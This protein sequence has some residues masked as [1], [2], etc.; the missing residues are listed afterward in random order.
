MSPR[1]LTGLLVAA[2]LAPLAMS[3]KPPAAPAAKPTAPVATPAAVSRCAA[4]P[5][6]DANAAAVS[7]PSAADAWGGPRT[8]REAT[9]SERIASYRIQATLD[10]DKHTLD[11]RQQL[12]WKNR[13]GQPV[14]AVYLHLYLNAFESS[15]STFMSEQR[16]RGFA[17]RSDVETKDGDWGYI[18]LKRVAQGGQPVEW[19]FVQPDG[20]PATDRTVVRLDLPTPVAPGGSTTLDIDFFNQLPRVVAR[21]G[22]FGSFHL[23][24][25]WFPKIGVL[26]LPGERGATAPRWNV[27]EFHL[28]SEFYADFGD[29][30]VSLT[31]PSEYVVGATGELAGTPVVANGKTTYRYVQGDVHDF[32]W[33]A[34][35]R[36]AQ[37]LEATWTHPGGAPVKVRVLFPPEY[38]DNAPVVMKA[39]LDSLTYF[40][41]T[42]GRYP[43]R[44]VTAVIPP[45]NAGEAGGMEYPTFFTADNVR[46]YRP[47][48]IEQYLLDFVTIHE[49]GHGYFYGILASNEFEEPMLDEGVNQY[50]N[51]RMLV[52]RRQRIVPLPGRFARLSPK[53]SIDALMADRLGA[54]L[55][56]PADP[57]G[58]NSWDRR[59]SGSYATVYS[60]T[61][62]MLAGIEKQVGREAMARAMKLYYE[63]W[64]FRHPSIADF[65]EALAEGTG[66]RDIVEREFAMSV[67]GA[68]VVDDAIDA[69]SSEEELPKLGYSDENSKPVGSEARAKA[70]A[71]AREAWK[72]AHPN[73]KDGAGP[74]PFRT[75]VVVKRAGADVPQWLKVTFADGS[76]ETV[77]FAGPQRWFR[78][79]WVRPS[80]AVKVELDPAG[81]YTM[82]RSQTDNVRAL[83]ANTDAGDF[84]AGRAMAWLQVALAWVMGA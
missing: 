24:A 67:Y 75:R 32:A 36:T 46:D 51:G 78:W 52:D 19:A 4:I 64:K 82:D 5:F 63:R 41:D 14:C 8:G 69:F 44:T 1:L 2:C 45:Y 42:L 31:V 62:T 10:P 56:N 65:R 39:T 71:K 33:T 83:E 58:N 43:Y 13:S 23:V 50:W 20:G 57:L 48:G 73:A 47:G 22:Y 55:D 34:D 28:H 76:T 68:Q 66:R 37:P 11:G 21:T 74:Y 84:Y 6:A 72:K 15:G 53:A 25:Q 80:K 7:V 77:E 18:R 59:S 54:R 70:I 40:S 38:A 79:D 35:K 49:F 17:F 9:L 61:S 29:Y 30:D 81:Q 16:T 27:H 60:R 3:A 26:E 12:T